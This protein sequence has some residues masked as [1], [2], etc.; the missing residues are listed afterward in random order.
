M[1]RFEATFTKTFG[2]FGEKN[3]HKVELKVAFW[4]YSMSP[5]VGGDELP[6]LKNK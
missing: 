5:L 3:H 4:S 2:Q 1:P 6:P